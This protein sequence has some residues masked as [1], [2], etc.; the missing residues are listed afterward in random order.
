VAETIVAKLKSDDK[1]LRLPFLQAAEEFGAYSE[2]R[3]A[4]RG[5]LLDVLKPLIGEAPAGGADVR[6]KAVQASPP[7]LRMARSGVPMGLLG[8][9]LC[10]YRTAARLGVPGAGAPGD[11]PG[12]ARGDPQACRRG[13]ASGVKPVRG[14]CSMSVGNSIT[15]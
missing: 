4:V 15:W 12:G 3:V 9:I 7:V 13:T 2:F 11:R 6:N 8:P 10:G 5:K 1:V 14:E